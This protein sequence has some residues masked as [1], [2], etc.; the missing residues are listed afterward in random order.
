MKVIVKSSD[1]KAITV[2]TDHLVLLFTIQ[3]MKGRFRYLRTA[4]AENTEGTF[5][6][7]GDA[8]KALTKNRFSDSKN[9][10]VRDIFDDLDTLGFLRNQEIDKS[11]IFLASTSGSGND[12]LQLPD[13]LDLVMTLSL[14]IT[15]RTV[16]E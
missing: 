1:P 3:D 7:H 6:L 9:K 8:Q 16:Q 4:G 10:S 14:G 2:S 12:R 11:G 13:A 15:A 5:M